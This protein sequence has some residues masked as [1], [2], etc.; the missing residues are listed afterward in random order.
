MAR[1]EVLVEFGAVAASQGSAHRGSSRRAA[2]T[3]ALALVAVAAVCFVAQSKSSSSDILYVHLQAQAACHLASHLL[4]QVQRAR[5]WHA[6]PV[7][8]RSIGRL[9]HCP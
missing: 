5:C 2:A 9:R 4:L 1:G 6:I 8:R 3:V 7:S